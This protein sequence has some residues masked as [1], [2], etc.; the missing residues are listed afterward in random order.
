V[1]NIVLKTTTQK[2]DQDSSDCSET[3]NLLTR[4]FGK[5]LKKQSRDKVQ[6]SN[7][8]NNKKITYFNFLNYTCFGCGKQGHIK[9]ECPS[10]VSKEK[11]ADKKYEKKGKARR[12]YIAWQ[13]NDDL[14][15]SSSSKNI[16]EVNL[17]L[18][19]N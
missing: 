4:K 13:D 2:I 6:P 8:Y 18:M 16:K 15:S 10:I 12:A 5:F 17:C 14:S 11:G 7:R 1:K 19:T 3:L 9:A